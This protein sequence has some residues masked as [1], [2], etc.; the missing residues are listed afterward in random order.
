MTDEEREALEK[1][2][3]FSPSDSF[4]SSLGKML[5]VGAGFGIAQEGLSAGIDA[6]K[7]WR[8]SRKVDP[9]YNEMMTLHP[10]LN[11]YNPERTKLYYDQLWHFSPHTAKN[12]LA[13]GNYV[14][15]AMQFD[16]AAG[17]PGLA[18]YQALS[19]IQKNYSGGNKSKSYGLGEMFGTGKDIRSI[20]MDKFKNKK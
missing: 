1:L 11:S 7:D 18:A 2:A 6:V 14:E 4:A 5:A 15:Y 20:D 3:L 17:G 9:L 12:P 8:E 16:Q 19:D 10:R 13:A